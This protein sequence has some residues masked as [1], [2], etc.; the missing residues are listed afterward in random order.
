[1]EKP[2]LSTRKRCNLEMGS[3]LINCLTCLW[4]KFS[5]FPIFSTK[6]H[7]FFQSPHI[8]LWKF[9]GFPIFPTDH[10]FF[11]LPH[12]LLWKFSGY[13]KLSTTALHL[14]FR[15]HKLHLCPVSWSHLWMWGVL[16]SWRPVVS[17]TSERSFNIPRHG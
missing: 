1:M 13:P 7:D 17:K 11:Q 9:S 2:K 6:K 3:K 10:D 15:F 14:C 16:H 12:M 4:W 8:F 5:G